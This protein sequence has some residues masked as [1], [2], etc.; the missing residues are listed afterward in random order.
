MSKI[1]TIAWRN[2]WRNRT[3][4]LVVILSIVLGLAAGIFLV[5][6][7]WGM[8]DQRTR[9]LVRTQISH[10][11][12]H[13]PD[14][15]E[16]READ[17]IIPNG[18]QLAE[19][20]ERVPHVRGA[21]ARSLTLGMVMSARNS[22][23]VMVNGIYPSQEDNV[24]SMHQKV[25]AGKWLQANSKNRAV[26]GQKLAE[27]LQVRKGKHISLLFQKNKAGDMVSGRFRL[28]GIFKTNNSMIDEGIV[29]VHGQDVKRLLEREEAIHE[30]AVLMDDY[31]QVDRA[32][33]EISQ[34]VGSKLKTEN[35]LE[36]DPSIKLMVEN[37]DAYMRIFIAIILLA[38]LFG[39]INT[40]LMAVL[41]RR[42]E[43]GMLLS[44]GMNKRKVFTMILMETFMLVMVAAPLGLLLAYGLV[45][46]YG[47]K[48]IDLSVFT[49]GLESMGIN[50][51]IYTRIEGH[52]Y[53]EVLLMVAIT[54]IIAAIYPAYKAIRLNP[55]EAVRAT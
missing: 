26:I 4:S 50:S 24:T 2:I 25:I 19:E 36:L 14:F 6:L 20:I 34:L 41:E 37:F 17:H 43:L 5:S 47:W 22:R 18:L 35:W 53:V 32:Q 23:G 52:Y 16:E 3:R 38:M 51:R 48:G 44:V 39:I 54:A 31:E 1:L 55:A 28:I 30:I 7:S 40:M 10:I 42:R 21:C 15:S 8:G 12:I 27:R 49:E 13:H 11:Q 29:Y 9:E 46:Y 33:A 45:S